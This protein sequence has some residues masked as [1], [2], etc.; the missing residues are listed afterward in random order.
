MNYGKRQRKLIII[1]VGQE[2]RIEGNIFTVYFL[3]YFLNHDNCLK[4]NYKLKRKVHLLLRKREHTKGG[5]NV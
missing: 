2:T 3:L 4:L 5:E 1:G